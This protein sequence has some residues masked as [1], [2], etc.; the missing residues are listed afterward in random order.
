MSIFFWGGGGNV[1]KKDI[2]YVDF[3][4]KLIEFIIENLGLN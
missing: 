2:I 3:Y 1:S 4:L